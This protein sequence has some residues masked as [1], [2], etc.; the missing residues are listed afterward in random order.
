[1]QHFNGE[2]LGGHLYY[3]HGWNNNP[4]SIRYD[5]HRPEDPDFKSWLETGILV[6][7][8][9]HQEYNFR[10]EKESPHKGCDRRGDVEGC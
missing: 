3:H 10:T 1:M 9:C 7:P 8:R 5:C 2:Y 4:Q 6:C